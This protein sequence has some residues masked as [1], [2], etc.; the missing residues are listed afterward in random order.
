MSIWQT[1]SIIDGWKIP[2]DHL[3]RFEDSDGNCVIKG[4]EVIVVNQMTGSDY[5]FVGKQ[6]VSYGTD[7][8]FEI[9]RLPEFSV[10]WD[11]RLDT[12]EYGRFIVNEYN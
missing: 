7:D 3:D 4:L 11:E 5:G 10:A 12:Y 1:V 9:K 6:I 2:E 8:D